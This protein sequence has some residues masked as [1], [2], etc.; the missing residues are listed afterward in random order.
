MLERMLGAIRLNA[1]TFE[2]VENDSGAT[3]QAMAVVILVSLATG[4]GAGLGSVVGGGGSFIIGLVG[5]VIYG[6]IWWAA[7]AFLTMLIGTTILRGPD[8]HADWGQLARGTGF[9]QSPGVFKILA[10]LPWIGGV[11]LFAASVWQ[12]IAMVIAVRQ[13][14]DYTSTWR[15]VG[16]VVIAFVV[17]IVL[18]V[19]LTL[20]LLGIFGAEFVDSL[21]G[22]EFIQAPV[23]TQ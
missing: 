15:A 4:L 2:D 19:V 12:L 18:L 3:M 9:A 22:T 14:L 6:L 20:V 13:C 5:G 8:T 7:W 1:N 21:F 16:V 10:F 17:V 23:E 11:I